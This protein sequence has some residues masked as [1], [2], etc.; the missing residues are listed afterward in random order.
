MARSSP[1]A[2]HLAVVLE[3][4]TREIGHRIQSALTADW[5]LLNVAQRLECTDAVRDRSGFTQ[6]H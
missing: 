5:E 4:R 1:A 3:L 6:A 2:S